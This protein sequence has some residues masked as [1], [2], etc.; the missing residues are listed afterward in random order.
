MPSTYSMTMYGTGALPMWSSPVSYTA[1]TDGWFS[2]AADC[3]SRRNLAWK[4]ASRAR[5]DRNVLI[6]T[7]RSRRRSRAR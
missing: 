2:E 7:V 3:A 5:S 6:A 4:V 1:M